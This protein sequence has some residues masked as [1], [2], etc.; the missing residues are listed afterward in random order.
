MKLQFV[1]CLAV[2]FVSQT[3]SATLSSLTLLQTTDISG[4]G[5]AAVG[6]IDFDDNSGELW[7]ADAGGPGI[8][9]NNEVTAIDPLTGTVSTSFNASVIPG[10]GAGP[11]AL[12]L[13]PSTGN[14]YLFSTFGETDA[15]VVS[16][17]GTLVTDY[18][19]LPTTTDVGGASFRNAADLYVLD[20][21][22]GALK[23]LDLATGAVL[24]STNLTNFSGRVGA[25]GFDPQT[26]LLV[27][28]S[29][30]TQ[31][32]L[33][34]DVDTATVLSMTNISAFLTA[35]NFPTGLAFNTDG[36]ILY[37]SSGDGAGADELYVFSRIPEPS[38]LMICAIGLVFGGCSR[39][40][41]A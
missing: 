9:G 18:G 21:G 20:E 26:G 16:Q 39:R 4:L 17:A 36:S 31:E 22:N 8:G 2:C 29:T 34:I 19:S 23:T 37:L 6:G 41:A 13:N 14:L 1:V 10:L 15:G 24:T 27:A 33:E 11:D 25:A 38:T 28:Y 30:G 12:A 7:L 32:L 35:P 5:F 40:R 3:C